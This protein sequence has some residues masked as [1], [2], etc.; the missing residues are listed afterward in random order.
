MDPQKI[1]SKWIKD[2]NVRLE[3]I[4]LEET[5]VRTHFDIYFLELSPQA[6]ATK[7]KINR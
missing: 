1:N 4:K 3:T 5:I 7:A 6:K 2:I